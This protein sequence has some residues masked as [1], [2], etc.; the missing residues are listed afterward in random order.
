ML[1][2]GQ[3]KIVCNQ[4]AEILGVSEGLGKEQTITCL[5]CSPDPQVELAG[6]HFL[7]DPAVHA[8]AEKTVPSLAC[9][10]QGPISLGFGE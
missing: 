7:V 9:V 5:L 8:Q 6:N 1:V 10:P 2:V 4:K 3:R